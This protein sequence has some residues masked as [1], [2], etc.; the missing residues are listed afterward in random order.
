MQQRNGQNGNSAKNPLKKVFVDADAF[1]AVA[2][3]ND[4]HHK[5]ALRLAKILEKN[6]VV[7]FM[8]SMVFG[9]AVTVISQRT[10]LENAVKTGYEIHSSEVSIIETNESHRIKALEKFSQ[11][12]SKNTRFTDMINMVLMDE[13]KID[14]IFSFDKHYSKNGYKLLASRP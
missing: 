13:L 14:T 1:V 2:D 9:E 8:S 11:Q 7:K 5:K 6:R 4:S 12:T 10:S 3:K